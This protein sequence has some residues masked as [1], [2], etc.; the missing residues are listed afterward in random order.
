M[1]KPKSSHAL[2]AAAALSLLAWMGGM[3]SSLAARA[4]RSGRRR[5]PGNLQVLPTSSSRASVRSLMKQ[6][7]RE[8]GVSCSYCHVEDR[9]SG[10]IDYASDDNPRKHTARLMITMLKDINDKHLAQLGGDRRYAQPVTCGSCHRGQ[11]TPQAY[12]P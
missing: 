1:P 5:P 7:E 8:L 3:A 2:I 11:A 10:Y 12:E 6:Y 9:D 4:E